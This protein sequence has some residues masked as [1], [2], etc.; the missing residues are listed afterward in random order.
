[1]KIATTTGDFGFYCKTNEERIRE[2]HRAGFRY[3]DLSMYGFTP[4]CEYM[5]DN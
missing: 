3:I 4:E 1:M 5:Q 2:L